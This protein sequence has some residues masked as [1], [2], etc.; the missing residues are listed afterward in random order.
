[1]VPAFFGKKRSVNMLD[2]IMAKVF[3]IQGGEDGWV[4]LRGY[5]QDQSQ[6]AFLADELIELTQ[7]G[8]LAWTVSK[9]KEIAFAVSDDWTIIVVR[10][11][12]VGG[13]KCYLGTVDWYILTLFK[14]GEEI[15]SHNETYDNASYD[16]SSHRLPVMD[17]FDV[18]TTG[19]L[20]R[21]KAAH[22][23][24]ASGFGRSLDDRCPACETQ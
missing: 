2:G 12:N 22:V 24:G 9:S 23:C 19:T 4:G 20:R 11:P 16:T 10:H 21:P 1:M 6:K 14:L 3:E 7:A 18:A 8:L 13:S 17:V 5:R 15:A